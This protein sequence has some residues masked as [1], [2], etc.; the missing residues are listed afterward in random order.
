M[1]KWKFVG[2][3]AVKGGYAVR[4]RCEDLNPESGFNA[5]WFVMEDD[6]R[7]YADLMNIINPCHNSPG[8]R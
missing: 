6:A 3:D 4:S 8:F 1:L 7:Q 2:Y 5:A